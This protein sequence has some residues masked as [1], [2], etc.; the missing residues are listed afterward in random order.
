MLPGTAHK[1]TDADNIS[2]TYNRIN[3]FFV[4]RNSPDF[5]KSGPHK[6]ACGVLTYR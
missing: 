1:N 3:L 5:S 4:P 2:Y 6:L